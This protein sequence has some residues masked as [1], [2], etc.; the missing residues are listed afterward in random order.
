MNTYTQYFRNWQCQIKCKLPIQFSAASIPIIAEIL[1]NYF[2]YLLPSY[3]ILWGYLFSAIENKEF[4]H[5]A[6]VEQRASTNYLV[7]FTQHIFHAINKN[8][9]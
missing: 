9:T 7:S 4:H 6:F 3:A 8:Y 2:V 5:V 1:H